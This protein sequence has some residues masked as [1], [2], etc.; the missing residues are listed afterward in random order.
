MHML[1]S[2]LEKTASQLTQGSPAYDW[3]FSG[4]VFAIEL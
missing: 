4:G 2:A 3:E 1:K